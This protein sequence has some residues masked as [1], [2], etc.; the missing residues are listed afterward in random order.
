[1][2]SSA[3]GEILV[4]EGILVFSEGVDFVQKNS[5]EFYLK[6]ESD[7]VADALEN[8]GREVVRA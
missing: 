2:S 5:E 6:M 4:S 7:I 3:K 1:M 8:A